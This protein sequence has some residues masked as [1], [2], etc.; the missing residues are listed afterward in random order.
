MDYVCTVGK[1]LHAF[2]HTGIEPFAGLIELEV[3]NENLF[4]PIVTRF[5][6]RSDRGFGNSMSPSRRQPACLAHRSSASKTH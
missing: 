3:H 6:N 4:A 1:T 2:E 5:S